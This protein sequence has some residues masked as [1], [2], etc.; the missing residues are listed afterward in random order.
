MPWCTRQQTDSM[1]AQSHL[2]PV[3]ASSVA[4]PSAEVTSP[5]GPQFIQLHRN[6]DAALRDEL[7]AGLQLPQATV[8]PKFLYDELGS[9]LF[10]AITQLPEYYPTRTEAAIF[11]AHATDMARAVGTG[12]GL[13]D[14]GA[15]NCAKAAS[16][17]AA[18]RPERYVAVDIS[19]EFLRQSLTALARRHP[20]IDM[21]GVGLDFSQSLALPA[22]A[23]G[24]R[25]MFFYPGSSIGNFAPAQALR[26]LRALREAGGPLLIGVDLL[27]PATLL[28]PAYD[29]ALGVTGAF[30]LNLLLHLNRLLGADFDLRQWRHLAVFNASE[31]RIEMHLAAR[32][33]LT[34]RWKGGSRAFAEDERLHTESSYKYTVESFGELL[35][36]AGYREIRHWCDPR[37]WFAVFA[38]TP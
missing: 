32:E 35:R 4:A 20:E 1:P 17:F 19:V 25:P 37:A 28:E 2:R 26:F 38:A 11:S 22:P 30:N 3:P 6:D 7:V 14:L 23:R 16:L 24:G 29:D 8:S 33:P 21:L 36:Q 27:K 12:R 13:I 5:T 9:K 18:L 34:V 31:S 15:G 10:E